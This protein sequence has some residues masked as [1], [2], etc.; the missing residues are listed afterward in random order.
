MHF[1]K[2]R[3]GPFENAGKVDFLR[4]TDGDGATP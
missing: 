2:K 3:F 1:P 4:E